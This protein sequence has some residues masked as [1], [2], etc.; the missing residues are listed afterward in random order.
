MRLTNSKATKDIWN[1]K[2]TTDGVETLNKNY[3]TL[4]GIAE[5]LG[6]TYSQITDLKNQR[7]KR[8]Q[9]RFKFYP[10]IE[11]TRIGKTQKEYYNDKREERKQKLLE[12]IEQIKD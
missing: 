8:K 10:V 2:I 11:I 9:I 3:P 5:D 6:M 12:K 4:R 7:T 1:I